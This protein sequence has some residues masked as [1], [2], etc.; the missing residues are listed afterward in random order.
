MLFSSGIFSV[1]FFG[2]PVRLDLVVFVFRRKC[3][4]SM[5]ILCDLFDV[6]LTGNLKLKFPEFHFLL[7]CFFPFDNNAITHKSQILPFQKSKGETF[8][9]FAVVNV[10]LDTLYCLP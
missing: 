6:I 10:L 1:L 3:A 2:T 8:Y 7:R 9:F 4:Q 5:Y